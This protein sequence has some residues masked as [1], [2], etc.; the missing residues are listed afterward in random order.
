[1]EN[2]RKKQIRNLFNDF[3]NILSN[4]IWFSGIK[5][6]GLYKKWWENGQL[7]KEINYNEKG[8]LDD[9]CKEWNKNGDLLFEIEF[10]NNELITINYIN[11]KYT[12]EEYWFSYYDQIQDK[13]VYFYDKIKEMYNNGKYKKKTN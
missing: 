1:M 12:D 2:I 5:E 7:W 4:G 10:K 9:I 13:W 3:M 6:Y 11:S 8:E